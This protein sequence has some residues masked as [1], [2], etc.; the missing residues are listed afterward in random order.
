MNIDHKNSRRRSSSAGS[1]ENKQEVMK[2][3]NNES[4]DRWRGTYSPR[5][6]RLGS[7][8]KA[9]NFGKENNM[10]QRSCARPIAPELPSPHSLSVHGRVMRRRAQTKIT[11]DPLVERD[12]V[13]LD[14]L[15]SL[16]FIQV[17]TLNDTKDSKRNARS[18]VILWVFVKKIRERARHQWRRAP[19]RRR[20]SRGVRLA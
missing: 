17:G 11:T 4:R 8:S 16:Q 15:N 18:A 19:L 20:T 14:F 5:S 10:I 6:S 1:A 3:G 12:I 9:N 7:K 2:N 13:P